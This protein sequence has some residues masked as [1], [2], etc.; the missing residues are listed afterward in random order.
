MAPGAE[1]DRL[2][3]ALGAFISY[4]PSSPTGSGTSLANRPDSA[5][6]MAF[7]VSI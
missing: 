4:I 1:Q 2:A 7:T 3:A 5:S 6:T